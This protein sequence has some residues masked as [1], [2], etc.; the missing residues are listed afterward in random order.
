MSEKYLASFFKDFEK[1][2]YVSLCKEILSSKNPS[3]RS[4]TLGHITASGL[5]INNDKVLLVFHP[6]VRRWL[7]PGG[8]IDAGETPIDAAIREVYEETGLVCELAAGSCDPLDIDVHI[9]PSNPSKGEEE[10][11]HIDLLFLLKV[12]KEDIPLEEIEFN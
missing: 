4:N 7:Q 2:P 6:Y 12:I 5:V 8:H 3:S 10:H 9:I 1:D 11:L